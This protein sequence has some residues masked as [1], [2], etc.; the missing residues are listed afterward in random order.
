ME[1]TLTL[2]AAQSLDVRVLRSIPTPVA[3][4]LQAQGCRNADDLLSNP[5]VLDAALAEHHAI[6]AQEKAIAMLNGCRR[7]IKA[8]ADAW[9][10]ADSALS[11][12]QQAQAVQPIPLPCAGLNQVL[13]NALRPGGA[14]LE[15]FGLP[16]SGKT[17]FCLQLCASGQIS[18]FSPSQGFAEAVFVDTE[19]SFVPRRYLQVCRALLRESKFAGNA[20]EQPS[21][22][23]SILRR[24]HVCRAYDATE[25]YATIKH[26]GTFIKARGKVRV[27]VVDSLAFSFR[28][29]LTDDP[30]H[31]ARVLA[32]IAATLRSLGSEHNLVVVVTNHMTTKFNGPDST[33]WLAPALGESWAHQPSTQLRLEKLLHVPGK[34]RATLTKSV[35]QASGTSCLFQVEE[36]GLRDVRS[37]AE[38]LGPPRAMPIQAMAEQDVRQ[39]FRPGWAGPQSGHGYQSG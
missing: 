33:G 11:L 37:D 6:A 13:G 39:G 29:E 26:L 7:E 25:L 36:A 14:F 15:V 30:A 31:R 27:L 28:H 8:A 32:D 1:A 17:Q 3:D 24:L 20:A 21:Q 5:K 34:N 16:G 12:L 9:A 2:S 18:G 23:E 4:S 38:H 35:E 19:G 22:L 10:S